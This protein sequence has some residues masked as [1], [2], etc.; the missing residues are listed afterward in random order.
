MF[1]FRTATDNQCTTVN[2]KQCSISY[3][4]VCKNNSPQ[5][6]RSKN[7]RWKRS[8][9]CL[10]LFGNRNDRSSHRR[11][12]GQRTSYGKKQSSKSSCRKVPKKS[13][14]IVPRQ[15]C[16]PVS[17]Q[18]P[19]QQCRKVPKQSCQSVP[20]QNCNPVSRQECKAVPRQSCRTVP[21]QVSKLLNYPN[22]NT[23]SCIKG[24]LEVQDFFFGAILPAEPIQ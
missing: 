8:P 14:Q 11:S 5:M 17:R 10:E 3:E 6:S 1:I 15:K 16:S 22:L 19:E 23:W 7:K 21:K 12:Y 24:L 20:R 18:V 4:L 9:V 13:C 2:E